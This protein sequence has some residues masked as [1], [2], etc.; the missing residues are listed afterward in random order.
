MKNT[1][2]VPFRQVYCW[3]WKQWAKAV[4]WCHLVMRMFPRATEMPLPESAPR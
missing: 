3:G 1:I 4:I 2:K